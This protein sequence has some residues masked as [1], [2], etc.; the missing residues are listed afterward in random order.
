MTEQEDATFLR[1]RARFFQEG[2]NDDDANDLAFAMTM[3]DREQVDL[4]LC[5]ECKGM[6]GRDCTFIKD[7]MVGPHNNCGSFFSVVITSN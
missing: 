2:L 1:R 6:V 3:R 4:R 7:N 5:F